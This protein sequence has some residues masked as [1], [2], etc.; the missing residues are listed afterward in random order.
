MVDV[1]VPW[2]YV[3]LEDFE[4][5]HGVELA[6]ECW[7]D[8][9]DLS[10]WSVQPVAVHGLDEMR[11]ARADTADDGWCNHGW[12]MGC[13]N[14]GWKLSS[15]YGTPLTPSTRRARMRQSHRMGFSDL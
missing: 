3:L 8:W 12:C 14:N 10:L 15:W 1:K 13:S 4:V 2:R 9:R 5:F 6:T 11:H 7:E